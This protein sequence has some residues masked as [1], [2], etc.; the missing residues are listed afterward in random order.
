[1]RG[2]LVTWNRGRNKEGTRKDG[3]KGGKEGVK[4]ERGGG[5]EEK[6][7]RLQR[8]IQYFYFSSKEMFSC[9]SVTVVVRNVNSE[10]L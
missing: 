8:K 1:M 2:S 6:R 4:V 5:K 3:R 10:E 7:K 9:S